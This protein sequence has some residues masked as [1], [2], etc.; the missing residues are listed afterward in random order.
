MSVVN[1]R[2]GLES[3]H[4]ILREKVKISRFRGASICGR[5]KHKSSLFFV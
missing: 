5:I 4:K 1:L 2:F 3:D